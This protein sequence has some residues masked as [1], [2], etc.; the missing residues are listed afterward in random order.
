MIIFQTFGTIGKGEDKQTK[1][2]TITATQYGEN[3]SLKA[4]NLGNG[5]YQTEFKGKK[6][7]TNDLR[8]WLDKNNIILDLNSKNLLDKWLSEQSKKGDNV[9]QG[10][11]SEQG[12]NMNLTMNQSQ[13]EEEKKAFKIGDEM[14]QKRNDFWA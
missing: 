9:D 3:V 1:P 10:S 6:E 12:K 13:T 7:I 8:G 14:A 11:A 4:T 5:Q 2:L